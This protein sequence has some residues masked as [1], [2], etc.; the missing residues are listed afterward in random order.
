MF[1]PGWIRD[2]LVLLIGQP[3][4][5]ELWPEP[6][7]RALLPHVEEVG[8]LGVHDVVVVGGVNADKLVLSVRDTLQG[9]DLYEQQGDNPFRVAAYRRAAQT[10]ASIPERAER[11]VQRDGVAG[12]VKLSGVG[13]GI[14]R[15]IY[16][17]VAT[18]R[19]S[20]LERLQGTLDP[21]HLFQT[22]PG[23]GPTLAGQI[24]DELGV[25][26]LE[27]LELAAYDGR[28][29]QVS[30]MGPRRCSAVRAALGKVLSRRG[31]R[32]QLE[33]RVAPPIA[34]L[35]AVDRE[36]REKARLG[37]LPTIAPRRFN[38][39]GEAWLPVMHAKRGQW[40]YTAL[41]SNTE[42]AHRLGRTRD[43][44]VIYFYDDDHREGQRTVV[45]E[46]RGPS[47]G[48]RVIRGMEEQTRRYYADSHQ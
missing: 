26:T 32:Q 15:A 12:L 33:P 10:I 29:Q 24:H 38:P 43:W 18:G 37:S 4:G 1:E 25:D 2:R 16:E 46:I 23:V 36:Y 41:F 9:A 7:Q 45:T 35:L 5:K 42:R 19:W 14:A 22:L 6:P 44:V 8:K 39:H 34:D 40:H 11:I 47:A 31:I 30:G 20:Q 27:A 13:E 21:I 48:L 3:V 28:L 17:I